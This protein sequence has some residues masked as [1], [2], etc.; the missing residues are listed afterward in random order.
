MKIAIEEVKPIVLD[1]NENFLKEWRKAITEAYD[2]LHNKL[3]IP[4]GKEG[5]PQMSKTNEQI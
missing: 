2:Y 1:V 3:G 5:K 4:P